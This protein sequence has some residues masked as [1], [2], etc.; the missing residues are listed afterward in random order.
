M[1]KSHLV[2]AYVVEWLLHIPQN[3]K[4]PWYKSNQGAVFSVLL[5]AAT[6]LIEEKKWQE[7][8]LPCSFTSHWNQSNTKHKGTEH[9]ES[10]VN[11]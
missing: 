11:M 4:F 6:F 10:S 5:F 2:S 1:L 8:F 9:T 7:I 3:S